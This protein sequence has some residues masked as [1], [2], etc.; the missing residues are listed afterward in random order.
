MASCK[1][2]FLCTLSCP[3][4]LSIL[5]PGNVHFDYG[6]DIYF[7]KPEKEFPVQGDKAKSAERRF[8]IWLQTTVT[9]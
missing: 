9:C 3:T 2:D 4:F 6:Q 5:G 7:I 8:V 1:S